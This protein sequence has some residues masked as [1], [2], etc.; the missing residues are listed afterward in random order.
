ML[1][2]K[3]VLTDM[4]LSPDNAAKHPRMSAAPLP[5]VFRGLPIG[6]RATPFGG[7]LVEP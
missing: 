7:I 3:G 1:I 5:P 4:G 2:T 6:S